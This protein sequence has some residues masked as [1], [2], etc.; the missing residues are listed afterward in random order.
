M[1]TPH[2]LNNLLTER[3]YEGR[4]RRLFVRHASIL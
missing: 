4:G 2:P 3:F 1:L